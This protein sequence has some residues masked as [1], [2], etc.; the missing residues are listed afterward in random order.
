VEAKRTA[1]ESFLADLD[2]RIG[3]CKDVLVDR[4]GAHS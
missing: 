2:A 3:R 1:L 4:E